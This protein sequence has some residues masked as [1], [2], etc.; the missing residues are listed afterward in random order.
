MISTVT[1]VQELQPIPVICPV[2]VTF[3][4][5]KTSD[6][7]TVLFLHSYYLQCELQLEI[8]KCLG[9]EVLSKTGHILQVSLNRTKRK[10]QQ[11]SSSQASSR[12]FK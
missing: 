8:E 1:Q 12:R 2:Q 3:H 5:P 6:L 9:I 10:T 4:I 7:T 11:N